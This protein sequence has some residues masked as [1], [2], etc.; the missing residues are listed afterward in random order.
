MRNLEKAKYQVLV[1]EEPDYYTPDW[2]RG[3][4]AP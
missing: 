3:R 4:D 1:I 2:A